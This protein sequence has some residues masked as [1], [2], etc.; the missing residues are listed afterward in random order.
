M[1]AKNYNINL[2]Y[3]KKCVT[4]Q[5]NGYMKFKYERYDVHKYN[6]LFIFNMQDLIIVLSKLYYY[7][8]GIS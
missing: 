1:F 3:L 4:K 8:Y 6:I 5:L 7:Y 2:S